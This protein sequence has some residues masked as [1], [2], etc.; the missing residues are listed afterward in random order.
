M[1]AQPRISP[2]CSKGEFDPSGHVFIV[3]CPANFVVYSSTFLGRLLVES[4]SSIDV[5][6]ALDTWKRMYQPSTK[7]PL[8]DMGNRRY[9]VGSR[10]EGYSG[11]NEDSRE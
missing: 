1:A 10:N 2:V 6:D 3:D 11:G 4:V 5:E 9:A 8:I 7:Y